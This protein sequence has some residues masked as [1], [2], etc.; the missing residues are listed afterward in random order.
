MI[1]FALIG[2]SADDVGALGQQTSGIAGP[3]DA[4]TDAGDDPAED[5]DAE[6]DDG[7]DE[8]TGA[9][10]NDE[11]CGNGFDDDAD[12]AIDEQCECTVG[13]TQPCFPEGPDDPCPGTQTCSGVGEIVSWGSCE[14]DLEACE[15]EGT[16]GAEEVDPCD[17]DELLTT[18]QVLTFQSPLDTLGA[19]PWGQGDNLGQSGGVM[20][21]RHEVSLPL[22]PPEGAVICSTTFEVPETSM[23]YDDQLYV[24]FND[25]V[26][27]APGDWSAMLPTEDNLLIYDWLLIR[28]TNGGGGVYCPGVGSV[29]Q[30]PDTQQDGSIDLDLDVPTQQAVLER[31]A[32]QGHYTVTVAATGDDNPGQDCDHSTFDLVVTYDYA[33]P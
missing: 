10:A 2:C 33:L 1:G 31:A 12:G 5:D 7:N 17:S 20:A 23:Y 22:E 24:L 21:A 26:I 16:T 15:P 27:L 14:V 4:S 25:V 29:C 9:P 28:G 32:S 6:S 18:Q 30:L 19:C 3:S 8:D 13:Q 11:V